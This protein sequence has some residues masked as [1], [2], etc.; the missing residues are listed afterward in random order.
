MWSVTRWRGSLLATGVMGTLA[1]SRGVAHEQSEVCRYCRQAAVAATS[2]KPSERHY[3]PDRTVDVLHVKLDVTPDFQRRRVAGVATIRFRPIARP[4]DELTL[5]GVN[6][7]VSDVRGSQPVR[8]YSADDLHV[9]VVFEKPIP[10]G[11]EAWV[12]IA[13]AAEPQMGLYFRTAA[14]GTPAGDEHCWTQGETHEARHWFPCF[15]APNERSSTEIVC[16]VPRGMTVV[17]NGRLTEEPSS[18]GKDL[19]AFHYLQEK[20]HPAYLICLVAGKLAKIEDRAGRVPLAFYTQPSLAAHAR[21]AF[22]ETAQMIAFFEEE[23]GVPY[24]WEKYDQATISDFM[25][26]GME[27]TTLTT[28]TQRALAEPASE[29]I[30]ESRNLVAHE[31]AHQWFGDYVTCKDW[32][33]LWLNEGFA[34]YYALLY[35]GRRFGRDALLYGLYLDA[36]D[37]VLTQLSDRRPIAYRR[38]K[39]PDEQFDFRNYPKASWVLHMLRSQA[40]EEQY[41]RAVREYLERHALGEVESEDLRESFEQV[42]GLPLDRFFDQWIYHGGVPELKVAY[43]WQA[44][45]RQARVTIKQTQA[46]GDEVLLFHLPTKLRFVVDGRPYDRPIEIDAAEQDF[47]VSLP[48]KP[49]IVRF[50]PDYTVLAK[51]DF[52]LPDEMLEA[53]LSARDDAIGRVLA[54]DALAD[55]RT[56]SAVDALKTALNG[57]P[58]FGVRQAAA[59]ALARIGTTV[60]A[61]ALADSL[62]QSDARVR[63]SVV[64]ALGKCYAPVARERLQAV[65]AEE[66]NPAIVAEAVAGLANFAGE[67]TVAALKNALAAKSLRNEQA[68][69][70]LEALG[71]YNDPALADA[72][73]QAI[74]RREAD[75]SSRDLSAGMASLARMSPRGRDRDRAFAFL[76]EYLASPRESLRLGAVTALGQLG[77]G[78]ARPLIEPLARDELNG[79]LANTAETALETLDGKPAEVPAE[80]G[81]LRSQMRKLRDSHAELEKS[82]EEL[83]AR[84]EAKTPAEGKP[85]SDAQ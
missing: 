20:S 64:E 8:D 21:S 44:K 27:N 19:A 5:D 57:D 41:R 4:L 61:A 42:T 1:I 72:L 31:L 49:Q 12:E 13:Y 15:D 36:R 66:K 54:C 53:Q 16:R 30:Q 38:Y 6:L 33:H 11:Q 75:V 39:T 55:R 79:R 45:E 85:K 35:E 46:V 83:K 56:P 28:L 67:Q 18:R 10:A 43:S 63:W 23:I 69:A 65:V 59:G 47:Y 60:S 81:D 76:A 58:F 24:P 82:V 3:A 7:R 9:T 26:G 48:G 68:G 22:D 77:D 71:V 37:D 17:S 40:G 34:T 25:W 80:L 62:A 51:V 74:R 52:E 73:M 14:D 78:R 29:N 32:S 2:G 84:V 70:A 50:D